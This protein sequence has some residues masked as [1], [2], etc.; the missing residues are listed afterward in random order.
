ML[1]TQQIPTGLTV[2]HGS[3]QSVVEFYNE[4]YSNRDLMAFL[5]LTG[6]KNVSMD[7]LQ[8]C[9]HNTARIKLSF[10]IYP[11]KHSWMILNHIIQAP[12]TIIL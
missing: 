10:V 12:M 6:L 3:N 4:Y 1:N 7:D 5:S 9:A 2:R 11:L 8:P